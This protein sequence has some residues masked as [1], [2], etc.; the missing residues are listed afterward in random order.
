MSLNI[1]SGAAT[2]QSAGAPPPSPASIACASCSYPA[3]CCIARISKVHHASQCINDNKLSEKA[4][5]LC[6]RLYYA[7]YSSAWNVKSIEQDMRNAQ[8]YNLMSKPSTAR[9]SSMARPVGGLWAA[10]VGSHRL[11]TGATS[12]PLAS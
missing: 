7:G 12:N 8:A 5:T 10:V 1:C 2:H 4:K 6:T 11:R 3:P 9:E